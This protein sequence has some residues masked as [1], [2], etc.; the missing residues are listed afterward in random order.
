[1]AKTTKIG[2]VEQVQNTSQKSFNA[3]DRYN[4][5]WVVMQGEVCPIML[6]DNALEVAVKRGE[7]NEE[8][9]IPLKPWWKF[10]A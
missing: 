10:W 9:V 8:D 5:I 1:M 4:L 2:K 7:E 6:T 3:A